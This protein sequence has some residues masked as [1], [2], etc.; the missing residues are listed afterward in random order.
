MFTGIN[1]MEPDANVPHTPS[2]R[3][4]Y[5]NRDERREAQTLRSVG[6]GYAAIAAHCKI[7]I[8]QVQYACTHPSTPKKREGRPSGINSETNEELIKL[9]QQTSS[10]RRLTYAQIGKE[11]GFSEHQIRSRLRK[12]G[13][14]RHVAMQKPPA[15]EPAKPG[16]SARVGA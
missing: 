8:R 14:S 13:Y 1:A 5:M 4:T 15:S 16:S 10:G 9:V 3:H 6:W 2:R 12:L 11:L 7:T